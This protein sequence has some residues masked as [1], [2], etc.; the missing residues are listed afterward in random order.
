MHYYTI[1]HTRS[2]YT[3]VYSYETSWGNYVTW[4]HIT[5]VMQGQ[6]GPMTD[7]STTGSALANSL[8]TY[9]HFPGNLS[10]S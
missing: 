5:P 9:A 7:V 3:N 2:I 6:L 1:V 4:Y 10:T 8:T